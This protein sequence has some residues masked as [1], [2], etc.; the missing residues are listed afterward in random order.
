VERQ[1][2]HDGVWHR[3]LPMEVAVADRACRRS[4]SSRLASSRCPGA[5]CS[6]GSS[7]RSLPGSWWA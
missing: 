1:T 2:G 4:T 7:L 3:L 6:L 5:S